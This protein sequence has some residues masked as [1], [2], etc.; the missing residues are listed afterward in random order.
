MPEEKSEKKSRQE[1]GPEMVKGGGRADTRTGEA[2]GGPE[3][4]AVAGGG[5]SRE[6]AE[7]SVERSEPRT[8]AEDDQSVLT[9]EDAAEQMKKFGAT[10]DVPESAR[11]EPGSSRAPG[12]YGIKKGTPPN[13]ESGGSYGPETNK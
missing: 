4:E 12:G 1:K 10:A 2:S 6:E 9:E 11:R 7:K 3:W 13:Q 8:Y 5:R